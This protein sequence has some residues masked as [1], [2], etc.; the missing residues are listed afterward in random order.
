MKQMGL[1][2]VENIDSNVCAIA[3]NAKEYFEKF[4]NKSMKRYKTNVF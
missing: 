4:R 2:E 1:Y 3:I